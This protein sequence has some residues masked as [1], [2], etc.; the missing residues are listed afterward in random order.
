MKLSS[1]A[2]ADTAART[3]SVMSSSGFQ[4]ELFDL[5]ACIAVDALGA[6]HVH[7]VAM[8]CVTRLITLSATPKLCEE[9]GH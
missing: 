8:P 7:G 9:L 5:V 3:A 4:V 2:P 1:S 6:E